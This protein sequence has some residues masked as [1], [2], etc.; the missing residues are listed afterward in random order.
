MDQDSNHINNPIEKPRLGPIISDIRSLSN[1][2]CYSN[3]KN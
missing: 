2:V 3:F 1:K